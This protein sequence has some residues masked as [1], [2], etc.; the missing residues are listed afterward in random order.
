M[1]D[2]GSFQEFIGPEQREET[3]GVGSIATVSIF[4]TAVSGF[5]YYGANATGVRK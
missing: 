2:A 4:V 3:F 5:R 1:L